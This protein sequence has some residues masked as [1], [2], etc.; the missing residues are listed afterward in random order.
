MFMQEL[1]RYVDLLCE[2]FYVNI[3]VLREWNDKLPN[4]SEWVPWRDAS[5]RRVPECE[6]LC[7]ER[8]VC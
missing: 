4:A 2:E 3:D 1:C 6:C 5:A 8:Y 7:V